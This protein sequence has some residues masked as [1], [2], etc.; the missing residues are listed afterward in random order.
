MDYDAKTDAVLKTLSDFTAEDFARL[1]IACLDQAGLSVR[2]QEQIT[3]RVEV[4]LDMELNLDME[5]LEDRVKNAHSVETTWP[6]VYLVNLAAPSTN[7]DCPGPTDF[8][9][10]THE[11]LCKA[12]QDRRDTVQVGTYEVENTGRIS[13]ETAQAAIARC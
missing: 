10:I 2:D 6:G 7:P 4:L 8:I 13:V 12:V 5:L 9:L 11:D 1:A 3:E